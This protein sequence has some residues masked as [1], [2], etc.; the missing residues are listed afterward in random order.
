MPSKLSEVLK[1]MMYDS[2]IGGFGLEVVRG[3]GSSEPGFGLAVLGKIWESLE[4]G[5][6]TTLEQM[7]EIESYHF[8]N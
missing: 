8:A 4:H 7:R 1:E 6:D 5:M 2:E 3:C